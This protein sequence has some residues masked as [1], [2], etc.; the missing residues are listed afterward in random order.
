MWEDLSLQCPQLTTLL[1]LRTPSG[2]RRTGREEPGGVNYYNRRWL[3][4]G[5]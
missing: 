4:K 3:T 5:G 1:D 2:G